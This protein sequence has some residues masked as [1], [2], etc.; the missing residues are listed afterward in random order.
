MMT[1]IFPDTASKY[2]SIIS[3][4]F[5][6][7]A[8]CVFFFFPTAHIFAVSGD[9]LSVE[10]NGVSLRAGPGS[11]HSAIAQLKKNEKLYE[12]LRRGSWVVVEV[13]G[14]GQVGWVHTSSFSS[15]TNPPEIEERQKGKPEESAPQLSIQSGNDIISITQVPDTPSPVSPV[16]IPEKVVEPSVEETDSETKNERPV[17]Q[18]EE[19][20]TVKHSTNSSGFPEG[21]YFARAGEYMD[22]GNYEGFIT[23]RVNLKQLNLLIKEPALPPVR[24]TPT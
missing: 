4:F 6:C 7:L 23:R 15:G 18:S 1:T 12:K 10:K 16:D 20:T 14:S 8:G 13:A 21:N 11:T 17:V 24:R 22:N 5:T 3:H 19:G 9:V 2:S